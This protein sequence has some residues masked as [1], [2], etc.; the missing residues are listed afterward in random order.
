[1]DC[2]SGHCRPQ[3][4]NVRKLIVHKM[5][6]LAIRPGSESG[7]GQMTDFLKSP[8]RMMAVAREATDWA[9]GAIAAVKTAPDNSY[10]DDDEAIAGEILRRVEEIK[11]G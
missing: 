5:S 7:L 11:K 1:M 8:D 3:G 6:L 10:G 4:S 2:P 9:R